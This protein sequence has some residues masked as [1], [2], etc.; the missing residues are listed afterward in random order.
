MNNDLLGVNIDQHGAMTGGRI[1][2]HTLI[3]NG[4]NPGCFR[5]PQRLQRVS[6]LDGDGAETPLQGILG[7]QIGRRRDLAEAVCLG[8]HGPDFG[9]RDLLA[10]RAI[11]HTQA[12]RAACPASQFLG[13]LL[14]RDNRCG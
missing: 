14:V 13:L 10:K 5:E 7:H 8:D 12:R 3:E 2:S 11:R 6:R 1:G 9:L 4:P